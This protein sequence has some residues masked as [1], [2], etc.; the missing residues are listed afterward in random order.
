MLCQRCQK[1]NATVHLKQVINGVKT[2]M[3]LCPECAEK[4]NLGSFFPQDDLLSGFFSN[5]VF[6][7]DYLKE[8]KRCSLC[9][10]TRRDL[11]EKGRAG[12]AKCYEVFSE[13][14][15]NI[16][17]GIHGNAVHTGSVPGKHA[18]SLAKRKEIERTNLLLKQKS[19]QDALTGLNNRYKLNEL[20]ELAFHK[21]Q[22]SGTP[23]AI[24]ILDIDYY[25]EYND[26]YGHQAGDEVLIR[27][28]DAIRSLEEYDGVH[29]ARYGGDEFV[30]IY[31]GYSPEEVERMAQLLQDKIYELNIEHK[32]SAVS[33][34]VS[35]SQ[36]LFHQIP[37]KINKLWDFLYGADMILY[38]VKRRGKNNYHLEKSFEDAAQYSAVE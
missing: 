9:G 26:N 6:G 25:K 23:L 12:C 17:Y 37:S 34:R 13:E 5:S 31:E 36:G 30:V 35:I 29:T 2:E 7:N 4:E 28:A 10:S 38:V 8:Q 18:E 16:I 20:A 27:I 22:S 21:A 3:L 1:N 15:A 14:L 19:E 33:D 11:A 32:F 24:E